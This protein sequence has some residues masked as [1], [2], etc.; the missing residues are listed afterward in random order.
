VIFKVTVE[1]F[2]I[3]NVHIQHKLAGHKERI[4]SYE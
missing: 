2:K 1:M 3:E 4:F